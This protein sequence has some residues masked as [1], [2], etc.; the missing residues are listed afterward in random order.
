MPD[1]RIIIIAGP[2]GAGKTTFA[3]EFLPQEAD[4]PRFV[5]ADLIA[6][7]VSPFAPAEAAFEAGR[8]MLSTIDRYVESGLAFGFETTLST[9]SYAPRII[10]WRRRGYHVGLYFLSLPDPEFAIRRVAHRVSQGGHDIPATV[11]R[12]RFVRGWE[13]F[14]YLYRDI[15]DEWTLYDNAGSQPRVIEQRSVSQ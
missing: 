9:R 13:N 6:A 1:R 11:I 14:L 2:N 3:T 15:V 8:I 4:C 10:E 5:N 12:R 7:G